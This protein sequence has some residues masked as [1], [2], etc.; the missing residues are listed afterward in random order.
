MRGSRANDNCEFTIKYRC[1][2]CDGK[3]VI[4]SFLWVDVYRL[5][6]R[7]RQ[8]IL[9][10]DEYAADMRLRLRTH[11]THGNE[12]TM[13]RWPRLYVK[14]LCGL[15]VVVRVLFDKRRPF[16]GQ[17]FFGGRWL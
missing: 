8:Y 15:L 16:T 10:G 13:I 12:N 7:L 1:P 6:S 2:V 3:T 17:V 4:L 11:E 14:D 5:L 9:I